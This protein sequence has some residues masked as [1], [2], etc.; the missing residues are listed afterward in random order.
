VEY[1]GVRSNSV[2][3]PI[4]ASSPGLFTVDTS[5]AGPGVIVDPLGNLNSASNPA[6]KG[7]VVIVYA[8]GEGQTSDAGVDGKLAVAPYPKPLLPVSVTIDGIEAEVTY[9]GAA[10]F[11][12]AGLIQINVQIPEG[13]HSG[14][15]PIVLKIGA[16][17]SQTGATVAVQ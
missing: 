12:V 5:G 2:T 1:K 15:V 3:L 7:S 14:A 8:T 4:V 10:P 13:A 11:L 17:Q 16:F 9:A 6:P